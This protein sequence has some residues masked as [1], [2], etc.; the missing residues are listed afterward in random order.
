MWRR[1]SWNREKDP[2]GRKEDWDKVWCGKEAFKEGELDNHNKD[3]HNKDNI[4][5]DK[6]AFKRKT[7]FLLMHC[8]D[9]NIQSGEP[10]T[11]VI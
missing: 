8:D 6:A 9:Q 10:E 1:A 2:G 4:D 3:N 11:D 7:S 5:E